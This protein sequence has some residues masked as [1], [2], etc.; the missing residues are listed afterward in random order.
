VERLVRIGDVKTSQGHST[1]LDLPDLLPL[2]EPDAHAWLWAMQ[3]VPWITADEGWDFNLP[4][5]ER[6][7]VAGPRG[8]S[9]SFE[10]LLRLG[11]R[12]IQ[13]VW[14]E[15]VAADRPGEMVTASDDAA[16]VGRRAHAG[17]AAIDSTYWLVG[18]PAA[19]VARFEAKFAEVDV[20]DPSEWIRGED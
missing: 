5:L 10:E 17:L 6:D 2:L 7:V 20:L 13:V 16:T 15:F 4:V 14:G 11:Q 19:V 1:F 12:V 9:L 8:L 3:T 18:G